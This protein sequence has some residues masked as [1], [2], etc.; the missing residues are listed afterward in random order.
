MRAF[1][2]S[3]P[4]LCLRDVEPAVAFLVDGLGFVVNGSVGKPPTWAS[5]GRDGVEIMLLGGDYP[6]PAK[7]WAAYIYVDDA[8]ALHAEFA[9]RGVDVTHPT[10]NPYG[11]REFETRMPDG[12][13]LAFGGPIPIRSE[14]DQ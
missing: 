1:R 9:G 3:A 12:R 14:N 8:D 2:A 10:D 5:L 6:A 7:D 13:L 4:V 11:N